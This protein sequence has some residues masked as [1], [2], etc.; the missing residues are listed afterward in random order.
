MFKKLI[1][2]KT[3]DLIDQGYGYSCF[4]GGFEGKHKDAIIISAGCTDYFVDD[5]D[6]EEYRVL[7]AEQEVEAIEYQEYLEEI[8]YGD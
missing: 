8:G 6:C 1:Q 5:F 3:N 7:M 4:M 2:D